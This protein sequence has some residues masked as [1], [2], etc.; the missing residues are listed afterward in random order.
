MSNYFKTSIDSEFTHE[1]FQVQLDGYVGIRRLIFAIV[2]FGCA[3][4][5]SRFVGKSCSLFRDRRLFNRLAHD[6]KCMRN[7]ERGLLTK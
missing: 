6:G 5:S 1:S 2:Y 3:D 4:S 7:I